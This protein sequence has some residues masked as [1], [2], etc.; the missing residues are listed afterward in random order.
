MDLLTKVL[1]DHQAVILEKWFDAL[2]DAYP[3]E[4]A[5]I[6][7]HV[8]DPFANPVG[9]SM[10]TGLEAILDWLVRGKESSEV[11]AYLDQIVRIRAV[12]EGLP[13]QAVSFL[14]SL[15][16]IVGN[17]LEKTTAPREERE[18]ARQNWEGQIDRL[19][20]MSMD[21]Y[22]QCREKIFEL[23]VDEV[24][25]QVYALLRQEKQE[26]EKKSCEGVPK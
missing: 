9:H 15:K 25:R 19:L 10:V 14:I 7:K 26:R 6:F 1:Q 11:A 20:L 18:T 5:R 21:I 4:A 13:S 22:A 23:K 24:H 8:K 17:V 2:L 12:Q 3:A 16:H